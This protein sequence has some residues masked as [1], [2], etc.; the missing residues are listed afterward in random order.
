MGQ[1]VGMRRPRG[2]ELWA[3]RM[4]EA[5]LGATVRHHDDGSRPRMYDFD[6]QLPG[7]GAGAV[8]VTAAADAAAIEQWNLMNR[9][10]RWIVEGL[11]GGWSVGVTV[12][13]SWK[14]L[15][16]GLPTLLTDL[17]HL[18]IRNLDA[19]NAIGRAVERLAADLGVQ[20]AHQ[21]P[22]DFVGSIY[23]TFDMPLDRVGGI[24]PTSGDP[25]ATWLSEFLRERGQADVLQ[26][27]GS[28][29]ADERHAFIFLPGFNTAPF[30]VNDLLFRSDA[31]LPTAKPDLPAP[32]THVWAVSMW[33]SGVGVR[34]DPRVGWLTFDKRLDER[35]TV[36]V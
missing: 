36:T 16:R 2:E 5:A 27:L 1:N 30:G 28:S 34:W 32:L 31:P 35:G 13:S 3:A 18:G 10:D 15:K 21:G 22:T 17:E 33:T 7:G 20:S 12:G 25:L 29:V 24:V 23:M 14:R 6:V 8:E 26:K 9:G 19:E 4:I 11:R